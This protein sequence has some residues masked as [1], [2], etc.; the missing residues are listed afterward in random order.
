M[1]SDGLMQIPLR[2]FSSGEDSRHPAHQMRLFR[3]TKFSRHPLFHQN[4]CQACCLFLRSL[5][6]T[7]HQRLYQVSPRSQIV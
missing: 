6:Q 7:H 2:F 1:N 3:T 4:R 5:N